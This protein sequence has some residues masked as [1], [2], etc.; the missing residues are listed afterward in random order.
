MHVVDDD[1][2]INFSLPKGSKELRKRKEKTLHWKKYEIDHT[3]TS[4]WISWICFNL[5]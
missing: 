1:Q 2:Q 3:E 4:L 5:M